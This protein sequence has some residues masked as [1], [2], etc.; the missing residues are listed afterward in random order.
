[1]HRL[2]HSSLDERDQVV[3]TSRFGA[4]RV[5]WADAPGQFT[6]TLMFRVGRADETLRTLGATHL[7]EH[8][9][10]PSL[11]GQI[12][13]QNGWVGDSLT[14]F[15]AAGTA[16]E[17]VDFLYRVTDSLTALPFERLAV[18]RRILA[19]ERNSRERGIC[20]T[21][22]SLRFGLEGY[23]LSSG[24]EFG[25]D[26]LASNELDAWSKEYFTDGNAVLWLSGE[27]PDDLSLNLPA[28]LSVPPPTPRPLPGLV[29]PAEI[30]SASASVAIS[31]LG[32]RSA[33]LHAGF[34]VLRERAIAKLRE[35]K[36]ISYAPDGAYEPLD[37]RTVHLLFTSDCDT[38]DAAQVRSLLVEILDDLASSGPTHDE[39]E[40]DRAFLERWVTDTSEPLSRVDWRARNELFGVPTPSSE[41]LLRER[42]ELTGAAVMGA[43][44][45]ALESLLVVVPSGTP[46]NRGRSL[47]PYELP[48]PRIE[49]GR[50]F[51]TTDE[52]RK[53][54]LDM[55]LQISETGV[56]YAYSHTEKGLPEG[57]GVAL[58][59]SACVAGARLVSG[60]L[61][62]FARDGSRVTIHPHRYVDG[63]VAL[64]MLE[65]AL[66]DD[67][68]IPLSLEEATIAT[69]AVT[70]LGSAGVGRLGGEI[71][72]LPLA[73]S[74]RETLVRLAEAVRGDQHGLLAVTD[75]R[76]MFLFCG[77]Q[78]TE[79]F[80]AQLEAAQASV[81]GVLRKRLV[82]DDGGAKTT[83]TGLAPEGRMT[84]VSDLITLPVKL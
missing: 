51:K 16:G 49:G 54:K 72:L 84:Q 82:I 58:E 38:R 43:M 59:F 56:S 60:G 76:I 61:L 79:F 11:I 73:V 47:P 50:S 74:E 3:R 78:R 29:L 37:G 33:A 65:G 4:L 62:V 53:F 44:S 80:E 24:Y 27:P 32:E 81:S 69:F 45:Q 17:V 25:V 70:E 2:E 21:V 10:L 19:A 57:S 64:Q 7:V 41:E 35:Q 42:E 40:R 30:E 1:M 68:L 14:G 36:G 63:D 20:A 18:E 8:L 9:A 12:T 15:Y 46:G 83:F 34:F 55:Q 31:M 71:D 28:G 66:G 52:W 67:R 48:E 39:L 13:P 6:G 77:A 5:L 22:S 75:E 26:W 23:G